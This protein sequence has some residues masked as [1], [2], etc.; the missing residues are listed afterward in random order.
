[1]AAKRYGTVELPSSGGGHI[2]SPPPGRYL[3]PKA[4]QLESGSAY[5]YK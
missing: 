5:T 4:K 3:V 1:M 2:V